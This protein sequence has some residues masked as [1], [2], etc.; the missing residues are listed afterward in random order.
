MSA[1]IDNPGD[2]DLPCG[3]APTAVYQPLCGSPVWYALRVDSRPA[4]GASLTATFADS[5]RTDEPVVPTGRP[6]FVKFACFAGYPVVSHGSARQSLFLQ[7][8]EWKTAGWRSQSSCG[9]VLCVS[10]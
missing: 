3:V 9:G 8:R 4:I 2:N 7:F 1:S 6:L 10:L 5:A